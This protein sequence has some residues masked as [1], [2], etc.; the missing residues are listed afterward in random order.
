[1]ALRKVDTDNGIFYL[2]DGEEICEKCS[3]QGRLTGDGVDSFWK[4]CSTCRGAG[5]LDWVEKIV[6]KRERD[7]DE[8]WRSYV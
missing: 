5:K 8:I 2:R 6:G 4:Q 3:G 1:M 7:P